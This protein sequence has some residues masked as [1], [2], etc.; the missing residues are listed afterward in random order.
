M[1]FPS[2]VTEEVE[3]TTMLASLEKCWTELFEG[4]WTNHFPLVR[5]LQHSR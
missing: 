3:V 2:N 4:Q 5:V 1:L